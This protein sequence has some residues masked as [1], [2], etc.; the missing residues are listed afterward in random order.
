MRQQAMKK[1]SLTLAVEDNHR[2]FARAE[3][4]HHILRDDV[5]EKS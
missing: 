1:L 5:F 4:P 2:H 3:A